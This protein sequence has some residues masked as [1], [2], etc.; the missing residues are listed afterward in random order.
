MKSLILLFFILGLVSSERVSLSVKACLRKV[1]GRKESRLILRGYRDYLDKN[2]NVSF[3]D[4]VF[5]EKRAYILTVEDCIEK[6]K[7]RNLTK[8]FLDEDAAIQKEVKYLAEKKILN[9]KKKKNAILE[10]LKNSKVSNAKQTCL[11]FFN[12]P[13]ICQYVVDQ[14]SKEVTKSK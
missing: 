11:N 4:Y 13:N 1:L 14:L 5:S 12:S 10:E 2:K 9:D 8:K 6:S 7:K 3:K